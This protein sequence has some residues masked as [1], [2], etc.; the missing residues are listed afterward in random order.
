[1]G[2]RKEVYDLQNATPIPTIR[3]R[4]GNCRLPEE[5]EREL[6]QLIALLNDAEI[7]AYLDELVLSD[8][9]P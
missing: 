3:R 5:V 6:I 4:I 1:M 7:D 2:S 8:Q 9:I